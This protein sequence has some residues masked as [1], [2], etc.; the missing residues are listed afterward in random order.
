[1]YRKLPL[2]FLLLSCCSMRAVPILDT[3]SD[4][5]MK[6]G[7]GID[8]F[9]RVHVGIEATF[10]GH[11][12][13]FGSAWI[14]HPIPDGYTGFSFTSGTL[15]ILPLDDSDGYTQVLVMVYLERGPNDRG[16]PVFAWNNK[17]RGS[18]D[19]DSLIATDPFIPLHGATAITIWFQQEGQDVLTNIELQFTGQLE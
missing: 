19:S 8:Q 14:T 16:A 6:G 11:D 1:M 7:I 13:P 2:L 5:F 18:P 9:G 3:G 10:Q 12:K 15:A 17:V 4:T